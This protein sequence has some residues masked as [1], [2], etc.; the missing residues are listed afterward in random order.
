MGII[1]QKLCRETGL[2]H[3]ADAAEVACVNNNRKQDAADR[4]CR[5]AAEVETKCVALCVVQ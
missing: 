2:T 5:H 4:Q 1:K 3:V